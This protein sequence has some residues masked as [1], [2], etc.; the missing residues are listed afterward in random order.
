MQ[1]C[2]VCGHTTSKEFLKCK[3]YLVS[4]EMFAIVKC[5]ACG[6]LYTTPKPAAD[7]IGRYY[8]SEEYVSH[9]DTKKGLVNKLYHIARKK[10][11][12]NKLGIVRRYSQGNTLAD[13]GCGTGA[14]AAYCKSQGMKVQ[15]FEPDEKSRGYAASKNGIPVAET[16]AFFAGDGKRYDVI[17]LWHVLEH[18]DDLHRYF[19]N[20][21]LKL[22]E[23][24]TLIIAVPNPESYDAVYYREHWA[25]FDVPRHLYHF[26]RGN[27]INLA[28]QHGFGV[29]HILPM[30]MDSYYISMLSEKHRHGKSR[31]A[32]AF[33]KGMKSNRIARKNGE[34]SSLIYVLKMK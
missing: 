18:V 2:P 4:G 27:L 13:V 33:C 32:S 21:R 24:G 22:E 5:E 9:S 30:K 11:L 8:Q 7:V 14:F 16:D 15:G 1:N 31:L 19:E 23:K 10:A 3:D 28:E 25:A 17:T 29:S 12:K 26:S 34:Y 6:M 20:F